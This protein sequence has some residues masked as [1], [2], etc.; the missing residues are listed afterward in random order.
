MS[1]EKCLE[2][3]LCLLVDNYQRWLAGI[4]EFA[5]I[6]DHFLSEENLLTTITDTEIKVLSIQNIIDD[7]RSQIKKIQ[8]QVCT[9]LDA[10]SFDLASI[11]EKIPKHPKLKLLLDVVK[12]VEWELQH[13]IKL[14][15]QNRE[16]VDQR[17]K[18]MEGDLKK[19]RE[20]ISMSKNYKFG[21]DSVPLLLDNYI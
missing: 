9:L 20:V 3:V 8:A 21:Q 17:L 13:L 15:S 6:N 11:E 5:T 19:I 18:I 4:L 14:N 10:A 7:T 16:T 1:Q 2:E 12:K